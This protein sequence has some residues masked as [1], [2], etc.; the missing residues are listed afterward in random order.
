MKKL[1]R[2]FGIAITTTTLF[3]LIVSIALTATGQTP[4][5]Q[6]L[7][8][9]ASNK[10][11]SSFSQ[12]FENQ[13]LL[14]SFSIVSLPA[15]DG[16][17]PGL[18]AGAD[19]LVSFRISD[20]RTG[21]PLTGLRPRAWF[22]SRLLDHPPNDSECKD[23]I[24]SFLGGLL[25]ARPDIDLNSY[26][27]LTL[28]HDST[29]TFINPQISFNITKLESIVT[30][31][32]VGA[33][34]VL[35]F[36]KELI[37]L[38]LPDSSAVAIINTISR[39]ITSTIQL[40]PNTR[41]TRIALQPD[42]RAVWVGLDGSPLVAVIDT[43][44]SRLKATLRVGQ[45]LHQIAFTPDSRFAYV[46]N[47]SSDTVSAIE[48]ASLRTIAE[49]KVGRTPAPIATS[50]ASGMIYVAAINSLEIAVINPSSHKVVKS[51]PTKRGVVA[52][53]F[54]P[55]GRY[56]YV[57]NQ[58]EST[59]TVIDAATNEEIA[60]GP[61][62][63]GPDQINFTQRYAYVRGTQTERFSL[64]D[65]NEV[66]AKRAVVSVAI[67]A[68][69]EAP[70]K[71]GEEIGVADMMQPTPE[72]N[73]VLIANAPDQMIYYYVEGM[74]APMG[75]FQNYKRRARGVMVIDRS[76]GERGRGEYT[77]TVKLTRAGRYDV[78]MLIEQPRVTKCFEIEVEKSAS[79]E[80]EKPRTTISVEAEFKGREYKAGERVRM[81][82][83]ITDTETG[84]GVERLR[85]V[86]VVVFEPPGVW[87]Q[88]Q[89]AREVG[90]GVY[91]V[92]QEFPRAGGYH[93]MM[94]VESRGARYA[95]L[96]YT[97]VSIVQ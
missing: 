3:C 16:L 9:D 50:L 60:T 89:W 93:V 31:P 10:P 59:V 52:M 72:G 48:T 49:I 1:N 14:V 11:R 28:N 25:S 66:S 33:D 45:G 92:T 68:G 71:M 39:K 53:R 35:S 22:N 4:G 70:S 40:D 64:I 90:E 23:K 97:R 87:Q 55:T 13:G 51:I 2:V 83:K 81:R 65:Q 15:S 77:T 75:T 61:V 6:I 5:P 86:Q 63:K 73:A 96:P 57:V 34:W 37:Y 18:V 29:I 78:P 58:V 12:S 38:S 17:N 88:R 42:G 20:K 8:L 80:K 62:V 54:D 32:S 19:A 46:T 27:L 56:A 47:S 30:L 41:P 95:D 82:F 24:R 94:R 79:G 36:D 21:Q 91:E 43:A 26:S 74:M 69:R 76:L 44:T 7:N 84:E 85:D 67:Q